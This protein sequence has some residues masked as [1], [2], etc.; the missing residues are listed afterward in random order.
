MSLALFMCTLIAAASLRVYG[1]YR[2]A[3]KF[4][5]LPENVRRECIDK[6]MK[7]CY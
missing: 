6:A 7:Y 5:S 4:D 3:S 2:M 1:G